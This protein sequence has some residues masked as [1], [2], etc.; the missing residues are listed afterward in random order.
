MTIF[1]NKIKVSPSR[2]KE[3]C[4]R[5]HRHNMR[6]YRGAE[7]LTAIE[8]EAEKRGV[9][10]TALIRQLLAIIAKDNLFDAI[11]DDAKE[12]RNE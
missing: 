10:Q 6:R 5:W 2:E 9:T 8:L 7:Y 3:Y 1:S 4:R 11:L 12:W